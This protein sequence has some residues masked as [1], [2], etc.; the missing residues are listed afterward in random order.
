MSYHCGFLCI[1]LYS[2]SAQEQNSTFCSKKQNVCCARRAYPLLIAGAEPQSKFNWKILAV[3]RMPARPPDS[4]R[5]SP[6]C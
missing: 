3:Q 1:V 2:G 4:I 6:L 5:L